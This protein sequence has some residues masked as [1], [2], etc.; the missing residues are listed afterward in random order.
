MVC[1]LLFDGNDS[2][3]FTCSV[4]E[5]VDAAVDPSLLEPIRETILKVDGVK[6]ECQLLPEIHFVSFVSFWPCSAMIIEVFDIL[7]GVPSVEGQK[8][9]DLIISGC[10]Y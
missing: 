6:V 4:L 7:L 3:S 10:A 5:L 1:M 2:A 8:S 9:W